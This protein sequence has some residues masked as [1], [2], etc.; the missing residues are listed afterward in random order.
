M[1]L[2]ASAAALV[3]LS[4]CG[5]TGDEGSGATLDDDADDLAVGPQAPITLAP[6]GDPQPGGT[7]IYALEAES[8]GWNPSTNRWAVSG[9][10]VAMTVFD[11]LAAFDADGAA[12]P[13]LAESFEH[14]EDYLQW[15]IHLRPG[16]SF[17][18]GTPLD[19]AAVQANLD[20]IAGSSLTG[21]AEQPIESVVVVDEL[22][23][24]VT[25]SSPWVVFPLVLTGQAG[26]VVEPANLT[27]GEADRAPVG[28]GPFTFAS[29]TPDDE[30]RVERNDTYW[31]DGLPYLDE[32]EFRVVP[33]SQTR[34][35]GMQSGDYDMMYTASTDNIL[36]FRQ[37][38]SEGQYQVVEDQSEPE[39]VFVL[40]NTTK[41]PL[42]DS[43]IRQALASATNQDQVIDV[44]GGALYAPA[45][46]PYPE[47]SPWFV[48]TEYPSY[49]PERARQLVDEYVTEHGELPAFTLTTTPVNENLRIIELL[50]QQWAEVGITVE[51]TTVDQATLI[52]SAVSDDFD[53]NLWRQYNAPD[54]DLEWHWWH[55]SNANGAGSI[56]LNF[57]QQRDDELSAALDAGRA[58]PDEAARHEAYATVQHRQA[59]NLAQIW[60]YHTIVAVVADNDI[61]GITNGPLPDGQPAMPMGG[62]FNGAT[63]LT[64]TGIA[65]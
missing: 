25:M 54:P 38:A 30:L 11:P 43:R 14:T 40:L 62:V 31:R 16:V 23:V 61:R 65:R 50:P 22:T 5:S 10:Q 37:L 41:E 29:W 45:T 48:E 55:E 34:A 47:S 6:E 36:E 17:H 56:S 33:D 12:Q 42:D 1:L 51:L 32:V 49:D 64:P 46:G 35:A 20:A 8:D 59:E 28:T 19:A 27:S 39:E 4:A 15:T 52:L 7:V 3:L 13:Y 24:Q 60:L 53:A 21:A 2:L 26:V 44:T 18:N 58:D 63:R 9:V 57:M